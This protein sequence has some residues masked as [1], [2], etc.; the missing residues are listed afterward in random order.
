MSLPFPLMNNTKSILSSPFGSKTCALTE[1]NLTSDQNEYSVSLHF[2]TL[3][4]SSLLRS[5]QWINKKVNR[6]RPSISQK[7]AT[8]CRLLRLRKIQS[9][10]SICMRKWHNLFEH[11]LSFSKPVKRTI[12]KKYYINTKYERERER[13]IRANCIFIINWSYKHIYILLRSRK[14]GI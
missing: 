7:F 8:H 12:R 10:S 9:R 1:C 2:E 5:Y 13:E 11:V 3:L 6:I 4:S 14:W